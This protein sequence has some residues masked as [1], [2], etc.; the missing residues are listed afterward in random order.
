MG[1]KG[2]AFVDGERHKEV[3]R[4]EGL[5]GGTKNLKVLLSDCLCSMVGGAKTSWAK[6]GR[7]RVS[8]G[9]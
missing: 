2:K 1:W 6:C 9:A 5:G 8:C 7:D 3:E 4:E